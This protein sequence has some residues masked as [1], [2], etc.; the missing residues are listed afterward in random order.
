MQKLE[1]TNLELTDE[2]L[3][4]LWWGEF[5]DVLFVEDED[6]D[7]CCNLVLASDW[8]NGFCV[9][10][11]GTTRDEIWH[12]FDAHHSKGVGWLLN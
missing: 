7:D 1:K 9:F 3:E 12:W 10:P 5:E 11:A 6:S 8:N 4:N 2:V